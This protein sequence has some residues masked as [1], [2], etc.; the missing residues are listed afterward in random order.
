MS[1]EPTRTAIVTG[2]AAGIG[3][4]IVR[5]LA[6]DGLRVVVADRDFPRAQA[7]ATSLPAARAVETDLGSPESI[8]ALFDSV[9]GQEGGCDVVV[10]NAGIGPTARFEE[11]AIDDWERTLAVNLRGALLTTQHALPGM[12]TRGW[13]RI[14]NVA[15]ISGLR[16]SA[17]RV[18]YGTSKAALIQLTRQAAI[19]VAADGVTVNA[20]APGPVDT[21]LTK[22]MHSPATRESYHRA[23][24]MR[25]YGAPE[26]VAAVVAFLCSDDASYVTG[27]TIPVDGGYMAAG[28]LEV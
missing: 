27:H 25:R 3:E 26:E 2:G 20:V 14:V 11:L 15:S 8:G 12:R 5:R 16:A 22:A 4:A 6:A 19:E 9:A 13:G 7:L 24:P 10:N 28:I 17:L 18:A 23:I 1:A 21:E